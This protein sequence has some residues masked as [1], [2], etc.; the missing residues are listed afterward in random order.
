MTKN[1]D[2]LKN[3]I[4]NNLIFMNLSL[5]LYPNHQEYLKAFREIED[6]II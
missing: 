3:I 4:N 2:L 6:T 5:T 1:I